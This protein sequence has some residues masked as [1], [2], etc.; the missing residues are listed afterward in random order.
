VIPIP[1]ARQDQ[2]NKARRERIAAGG[3]E[4]RRSYPSMRKRVEGFALQ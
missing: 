1:R 3:N 2:I 4:Y